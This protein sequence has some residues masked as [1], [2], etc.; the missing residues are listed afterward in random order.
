MTLTISITALFVALIALAV[1]FGQFVLTARVQM[2]ADKIIDAW[3]DKTQK[4]DLSVQ[5]DQA[6]T[7]AET[8]EQHWY[9]KDLN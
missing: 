7:E 9:R 8:V 1:S 6:E 5:V 4:V 2:A 3:D